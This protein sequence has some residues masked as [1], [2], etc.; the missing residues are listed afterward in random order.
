MI[1]RTFLAFTVMLL[2]VA[3]TTGCDKTNKNENAKVATQVAAKVNADEITVHQVNDILAQRTDVKPEEAAQTKHAILESL[4]TQQLAKQKAIEAQLDRSPE[5]MLA[6]EAAKTEILARAHVE[7]IAR[8]LPKPMPWEIQDYYSKHPELFAQRRIF[9]L[10]EI[11]FVAND[12]VAA[13]LRKGFSKFGS[14][15]QVADWLQ[16]RMVKFTAK[17][18]VRAAEQIPLEMLP[19]VQAMKEGE[20]E[21]FAAAGGR[22]QVIRVVDFMA[23]PIDE[24]T[25]TPR[26][27]QFLFNRSSGKAI[28]R[29]MSEIR[30]R[31]KVEYMG[32]FADGAAAAERRVKAEAGAKAKAG[33]ED[34]PGSEDLI[35][36]PSQK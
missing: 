5:V 11:A 7:G 15:K 24:A 9:A 22:F 4:I 3:V 10:E 6:I 27:R 19:K 12:D 2:A 16:S 35:R 29:E 30:A 8:T 1:A 21:L 34:Q 13:A 25:A 26:I 28:A 18:G 14:L 33:V 36:D 32:E 23:A 17:R 20:I 31:A